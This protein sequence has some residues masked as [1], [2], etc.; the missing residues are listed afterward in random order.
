MK[1]KIIL[2]LAAAVVVAGGVAGMSAYEAHIINVTAHIE[3]ALA[4]STE[5][6]D[7]GTV[8]PQEY[9]ERD[10]TINLSSSF[11]GAERADDVEY[12]INQKPKCECNVWDTT[13]GDCLEGQYAPVSYIDDICP[14]GYTAMLS[15]CPFLSKIDGD[16]V[17]GN[18]ISLP[19]Y[20]QGNTCVWPN[21]GEASGRLAKSEQ[22]TSDIWI[23]DL[24]VPPVAGTVGQDWP[25]GCPTVSEDSQ[26]YGCD[27]WIEVTGIS[28]TPEG[29]QP[30]LRTVSLENKNDVWEVLPDDQ[31]KGDIDYN[32]NDTSFKGVVTGQGLIPYSPYQITLNGPGGC[33]FTDNGLAGAGNNLFESGYWNNGVNLEPT[34]GTPGEGVYNMDLTGDAFSPYWYTVWTDASGGFTHNFDF[35]LPAGDYVGVKVLVKKMLNP[36]VYPWA[37][38]GTGYPMFNLYETAAISFTILP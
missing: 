30:E 17:D 1:K 5:A 10:F 36:F 15:L 22:D 21:E 8:F 27:L 24:K 25:A 19:S 37:D 38:T 14:T 16:P 28:E 23:I 4:V 20:F 13:P 7:F 18:D 11:L 31:T 32:H 2:G 34:C 29:P 9:L 35:A 6:L 33:T 26:D 3:N 12:I